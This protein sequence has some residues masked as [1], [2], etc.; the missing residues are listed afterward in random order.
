M[1]GLRCRMAEAGQRIA[2]LLGAEA[3]FH[4]EYAMPDGAL[5]VGSGSEYTAPRE[6]LGVVPEA[7]LTESTRLT[8]EVGDEEELHARGQRL[9]ETGLLLDRTRAPFELGDEPRPLDRELGEF[10][11]SLGAPAGGRR[12]RRAQ[13]VTMGKQASP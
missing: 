5:Y 6:G 2:L 8:L 7:A 10:V 4:G 11:A 3:V 9:T 1:A 13:R 12:G